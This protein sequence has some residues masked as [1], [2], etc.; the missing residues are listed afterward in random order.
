M[1]DDTVRFEV[2]GGYTGQARALTVHPDG[3]A[4]VEVSG[5]RSTGRLPAS[6]V[7]E[8]TAALDRAGGLDAVVPGAGTPPGADRQR[9]TLT[10]RGA[11]AVA[12]DGAVPDRLQEAVRLL[13]QA[14]TSLRR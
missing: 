14:M 4:E 9:Y 8:L 12:H 3:T 2:E 5:H 7:A 13:R 11:T 10:Y 6:T 1:A